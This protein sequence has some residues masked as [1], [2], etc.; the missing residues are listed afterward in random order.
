MF[1]DIYKDWIRNVSA[2]VKKRLAENVG[3]DNIPT[4]LKLS[5]SDSLSKEPKWMLKGLLRAA[6]KTK[7]ERTQHMAIVRVAIKRACRKNNIIVK[8]A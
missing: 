5:I 1:E 3:D 4:V 6:E 8:E 7:H 2:T